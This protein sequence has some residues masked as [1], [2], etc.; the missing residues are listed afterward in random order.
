MTTSKRHQNA[1]CIL[2]VKI[3]LFGKKKGD[4]TAFET[5]SGVIKYKIIDIE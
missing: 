1:D 5:P 4:V 2:G 3:A